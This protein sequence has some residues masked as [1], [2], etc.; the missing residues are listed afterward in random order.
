LAIAIG[1]GKNEI[2]HLLLDAGADFGKL[3]E[4]L[5]PDLLSYSAMFCNLVLCQA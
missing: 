1:L 4:R 3:P 2:V 5:L